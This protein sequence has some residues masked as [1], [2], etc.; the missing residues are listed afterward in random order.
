MEGGT[1]RLR[2]F[3]E[4]EERASSDHHHHHRGCSQLDSI[5]RKSEP[6]IGWNNKLEQAVHTRD[7]RSERF[8]VASAEV[9]VT[10]KSKGGALLADLEGSLFGTKIPFLLITAKDY[11]IRVQSPARP[12]VVTSSSSEDTVKLS[13]CSSPEDVSPI[14]N[15]I[16]SNSA[17]ESTR[18]IRETIPELPL[19]AQS[20]MDRGIFNIIRPEK[21]SGGRTGPSIS[22]FRDMLELYFPQL[23]TSFPMAAARNTAKI[24]F[25]QSF[26]AGEAQEWWQGLAAEQ[27]TSYEEIMTA[28]AA[29]F[30]DQPISKAYEVA[31][32]QEI[33]TVMAAES[34]DQPISK[35]HEVA[36][37]LNEAAT[38]QQGRDGTKQYVDRVR[39]LRTT[40]GTT[41]DSM[42]AQQF[43]NGITDRALKTGMH[44]QLTAPYALRDVII[45]FQ[46]GSVAAEMEA[47]VS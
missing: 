47:Q 24:M 17:Q 43:V 38:L 37:A 16:L 27:R 4:G 28:M 9:T 29:E 35:A 32:A 12:A 14:Q 5:R 31:K 26:L 8:K 1:R 30:P 20:R 41:F 36:K 21:F 46:K 25:L 11:P 18:T 7:Q 42:L 44:L 19:P 3:L 33:M 13:A 34:P 40:L 22:Q 45:L 6:I 39:K 15:P 2:V 23:E 10:A